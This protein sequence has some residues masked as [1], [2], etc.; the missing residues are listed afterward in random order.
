MSMAYLGEQFD[1]HTGGSDHIPV[2]HTNEIAQSEA[3]TGHPFVRTWL[4]GEHLVLGE[5]TRMGKSEG[6]MLTLQALIEQGYK[7][8]E[9]RYLVLNTHYRKYLNFSFAALDAAREA[10]KGLRQLLKDSAVGRPSPPWEEP[11]VPEAGPCKD[12]LEALCDDL[13]TPR[14]LA[15]LWTTFRDK[16]ISSDTKQELANFADRVLSLD[17]FDYRASGLEHNIVDATGSSL[18]YPSDT[19]QDV[20]ALAEERIAA[21]AHRDFAE[22]DRIRERLL[23]LGWSM[24]DSKHGY[25]LVKAR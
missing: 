3:A 14:A 4:H 9:Y 15:T 12:V 16:S 22:S 23:A 2:H 5:D 13:N 6:N 17:L 18:V 21:R 19:Q 8:L 24:Q 20:I 11:Q 1:I 10:L 7:P 25:T